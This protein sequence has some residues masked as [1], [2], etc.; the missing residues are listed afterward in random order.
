MAAR[1]QFD[2][3]MYVGETFRSLFRKPL[4]VLLQLIIFQITF[5]RRSIGKPRHY[6]EKVGHRDRILS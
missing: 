2:Y 6:P 1:C 5:Y 4:C 3:E